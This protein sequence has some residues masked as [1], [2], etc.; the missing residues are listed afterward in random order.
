MHDVPQLQPKTRVEGQHRGACNDE[1]AG[2][3]RMSG[4]CGCGLC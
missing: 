3:L 4:T 1:W 2:R